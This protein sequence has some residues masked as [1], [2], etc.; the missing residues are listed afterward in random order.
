MAGEVCLLFALMPM[1]H[2]QKV[3]LK[4]SGIRAAA[5]TKKD[6][7]N[8]TFTPLYCHRMTITC[9]CLIWGQIEF[10]SIALTQ[11]KSKYSHRL[12]H[13]SWLQNR[14]AVRGT[15]HFTQMENMH[16]SCL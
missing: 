13:H 15:W 2:L 9:L 8:R 7:K 10:I 16:T 5:S 12:T 11:A 4:L 3:I 1:V 6:K 14:E